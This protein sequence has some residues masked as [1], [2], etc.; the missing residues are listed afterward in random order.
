MFAAHTEQE[1]TTCIGGLTLLLLRVL[2]NGHSMLFRDRRAATLLV[3]PLALAFMVNPAQ[4]SAQSFTS[5]ELTAWFQDG[6]GPVID[7]Q[8]AR[9]VQ[10]VDLSRS[11]QSRFSSEHIS[12][13]GGSFDPVEIADLDQDDDVEQNE[14]GLLPIWTAKTTSVL[15][16]PGSDRIVTDCTCISARATSTVT[17]FSGYPSVQHSAAESARWNIRLS[18]SGRPLARLRPSTT[19]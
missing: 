1:T 7:E 19:I 6:G 8:S 9:M 16:Y 4:T 3:A 13:V 17:P 2:D 12:E 18:S 11:V 14:F 10:G 15:S 5:L